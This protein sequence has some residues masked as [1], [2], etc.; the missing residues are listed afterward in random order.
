LE[1]IHPEDVERVR[2]VFLAL[3]PDG[4]G[5]VVQHRLQ[6]KDGSYVWVE[7][8]MRLVRG[9]GGRVELI[10][11]LRDI[12]EQK[13]VE[14]QLAAVNG[15]LSEEN[16]RFNVA[17]ENTRHGLAFYDADHR[18]QV[19]NRP[20]AEIYGISP[21][22]LQVGMTFPDVIR[23]SLAAGNYP[24]VDPEAVIAERLK[25]AAMTVPH[26]FG[27]NLKDGRAAE[28]VQQPLADGGRVVTVTDVTE[29]IQYEADLRRAKEEAEAASRTKSEFLATMSHELRTPLNAI[30]GFSEI[31]RDAY[32][33]PLDEQYRAYAHD[34]HASGKHLL[35]LINDILDL[36]KVEVGRLELHAEVLELHDIVNRSCRLVAEKAH[37]GGIS[38]D[39]RVAEDLPPILADGLRMKQVLLNL[40][41]NAVKF[42]PS[43]GRVAV[44][45][46]V[47]DGNGLEIEVADTGI[48][49]R[50]E[51]IP[52][53]LEPFRQIDNSTTRRYEGTGLGLPLAKRLV[54]LH[55]GVLE[56]ESQ[57][58]QG[59]T[60]RFRIP[61]SRL[62]RGGMPDPHGREVAA[63]GI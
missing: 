10:S 35:E 17:L 14:Q 44:S 26:A 39:V 41:S 37:N 20:Y 33:G 36:S 42:T 58:G 24:G 12:R 27:Q 34:I 4:P 9:D 51:E 3:V 8:V 30:L 5:S 53:A 16:R 21:D 13:A 50:P 55:G 57:P 19:W 6:H 60:V 18:L 46:R 1:L 11:V 48:G 2:S 45:A 56:I 49:M 28:A 29:R 31:M 43:G 54:E 62:V 38:L 61:E 32:A 7:A 52:T 47:R 59:T 63:S 40:L 22:A 25:V 23:A 15:R